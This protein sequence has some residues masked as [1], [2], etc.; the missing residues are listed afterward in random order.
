MLTKSHRQCCVSTLYL[1]SLQTLPYDMALTYQMELD[2]P[3]AE[4]YANFSSQISTMENEEEIQKIIGEQNIRALRDAINE[5][6]LKTEKIRMIAIKMNIW[7][8]K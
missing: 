7:P 3:W 6:R 5:G 8:K 1:I 2:T 4:A